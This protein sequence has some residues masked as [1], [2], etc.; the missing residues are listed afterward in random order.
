MSDNQNIEL[1]I[2]LFVDGELDL[3][4][5]GE[6]FGELSKN[7]DY[8]KLMNEYI[9]V[10]TKSKDYFHNFV[11]S[12]SVEKKKGVYSFYK[13]A[14]VSTFVILI[15]IS[16]YNLLQNDNVYEAGVKHQ[17]KSEYSKYISE[18]PSIKL[19]NEDITTKQEGL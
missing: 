19:T 6:L 10:K 9:Q 8:I 14:F 4:E 16:F 15:I 11:S 1:K 18:I 5:Q 12:D 13:Y 17:S 3:I 7:L 2:S